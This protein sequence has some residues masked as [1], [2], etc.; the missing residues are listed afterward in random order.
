[1][2]CGLIWRIGWRN[3]WPGNF[4]GRSGAASAAEFGDAAGLAGS[5]WH[6]LGTESEG[7]SWADDV[8]GGG[9]LLFAAGLAI[10]WPGRNA[11]PGVAIVSAQVA[12]TP[13]DKVADIRTEAGNPNVA[14]AFNRR[15]DINYTETALKDVAAHLT[16]ETGITFHLKAKKLDEASLSPDTPITCQLTNIR[17]STFLEVMLEDLELTYG[18]RDGLILI[19]TPE[20]AESRLQI[21]VYD[22]RDLLA[23]PT[24]DLEKKFRS[25][26]D[27]QQRCAAG[28]LATRTA[29]PSSPR[30]AAAAPLDRYAA[31][32]KPER[33]LTEYERRDMRALIN[34]VTFDRRSSNLGRRRGSGGHRGLQR[35]DRCQPHRRN[36]SHGRA[37]FR[38]ASPG[39][40]TRHV[41]GRESSA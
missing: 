33:P 3:C 36:A 24:P 28:R 41:Q 13:G 16:K 23:M 32:D 6:F 9:D 37:V 27:P 22:C 26:C 20:D 8:F 4:A 10:F 31:Q 5:L 38:H 19:T 29:G 11:G 1:M 17:L 14:Q 15:M 39:G 7:G 30:A 40:R 21:R 25:N 18:E 35:P 2:N 12:N 34:M